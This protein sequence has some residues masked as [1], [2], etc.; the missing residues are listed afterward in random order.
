MLA[1]A[2]CA[3]VFSVVVPS[4]LVTGTLNNPASGSV[5]QA[6]SLPSPL[7]SKMLFS[8]S[9]V[10]CYAEFGEG[11]PIGGF[12]VQLAPLKAGA[13]GRA[14]IMGDDTS[15]QYYVQDTADAPAP[16]EPF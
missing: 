16:T 6:P 2:A 3:I 14:Y 15:V 7:L 8:A 4:A 13:F 10:P 1:M 5:S 9:K 11:T 12:L